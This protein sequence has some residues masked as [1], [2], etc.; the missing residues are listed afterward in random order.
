MIE[1]GELEL[2]YVGSDSD[3][4]MSDLQTMPKSIGPNEKLA[5]HFYKEPRN[6][7][8]G[9]V[10]KNSKPDTFNS[11]SAVYSRSVEFYAAN[12]YIAIIEAGV[13]VAGPVGNFFA[14]RNIVNADAQARKYSS[15]IMNDL[16]IAL[17]AG[18][19]DSDLLSNSGYIADVSNW[20][21]FGE[22]NFSGGIVGLS[23]AEY[24][25]RVLNDAMKIYN[26]IS[27]RNTLKP[28]AK[29]N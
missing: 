10:G 24:S 16:S 19:I 6:S 29:S 13:W 3:P 25:E 26:T 18:I 9:K 1:I 22:T 20:L 7:K 11:G 2:S 14:K 5:E 27:I 8:S 21:L 12:K 23:D 15:F 28:K 17:N 4:E